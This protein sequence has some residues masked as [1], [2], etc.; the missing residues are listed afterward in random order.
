M[1]SRLLFPQVPS[2]TSPQLRRCTYPLGIVYFSLCNC[3]CF[4]LRNSLLMQFA[5]ASPQL[6]PELLNTI[7][8]WLEDS[9]ASAGV[10]L[11]RFSCCSRLF[12]S[13]GSD[14]YLW[15]SL[16]LRRWRRHKSQADH[17]ELLLNSSK[18][19]SYVN[20]K[21]LYGQRHAA[22]DAALKSVRRMVIEPVGRYAEARSI[23]ADVEMD[24]FDALLAR[25]SR[26]QNTL[27]IY[28]ALSEKYWV[29][30]VLDSLRRSEAL[31]TWLQMIVTG[32]ETC[33]VTAIGAFS[34]FRGCDR[35]ELEDKLESLT[36]YA[37]RQIGTEYLESRPDQVEVAK[38]I[39]GA[40][41]ANGIISS[42]LQDFHKL[43]NHFLN[44]VIDQQASNFAK[45]VWLR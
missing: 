2:M 36:R 17:V 42:A 13:V 12:H 18:S 25:Q 38:K 41:K 30:D 14:D 20:W 1:K 22:D 34:G 24:V 32:D 23:L 9:E 15:R 45:L 35:V 16:Y 31:Q 10:A 11:S 37:R 8:T 40:M 4:G 5:M 19:T 29:K 26:L 21:K 6:A 28:E 3:T 7:L 33:T 43:R 39:Y 27:P 44:L